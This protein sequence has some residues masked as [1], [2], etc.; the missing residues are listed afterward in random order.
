MA[1]KKYLDSEGVTKLS[2]LIKSKI[3]SSVNSE[4]NSRIVADNN[5]QSQINEKASQSDLEEIDSTLNSYVATTSE[6]QQTVSNVKDSIESTNTALTELEDKTFFKD[7]SVTFTGNNPII[8]DSSYPL[9][10]KHPTNKQATSEGNYGDDILFE[11]VR[12]YDNYRGSSIAVSTT[13][14]GYLNG[15]DDGVT[16]ELSLKMQVLYGKLNTSNSSPFRFV[17]Y[18]SQSNSSGVT[19]TYNLPI[20]RT[21]NQTLLTNQSVKTLFGQSLVITSN[22]DDNIKLT[23]NDFGYNAG[24]TTFYSNGST[25]KYKGIATLDNN[26]QVPKVQL[27]VG[28]ANG[29]AELDAN[30]KVPE[31]QLPSYVDDV[32]EY[33]QK[34]EFPTTGETGKIYV[35]TNTNLTY[36]WSGSTYVEISPSLAIGTTSSTAFAGSRGVALETSVSSLKTSLSSFMNS[37]ALSTSEVETLW[38]NA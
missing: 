33:T 38:N 14:G 25:I 27:P 36:R 23:L 15:T 21:G 12:Q 32:L 20:A 5:L 29:I 35:A 3:T 1:D 8:N 31:S 6:L 11:A 2:N 7:K 37:G 34:S 26:S 4:T 16:Q 19:Y 13:P 28:I 9:W 24:S 30:G 17:G 10:I 22:T 18:D